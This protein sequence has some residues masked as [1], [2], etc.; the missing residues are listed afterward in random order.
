[1]SHSSSAPYVAE[2]GASA[3][4]LESPDAKRLRKAQASESPSIFADLDFAD[5]SAE[6]QTFSDDVLVDDGI[7]EE[8][9]MFKDLDDAPLP[10]FELHKDVPNEDEFEDSSEAI[11]D[12]SD[13]SCPEVFSYTVPTARMRS[14]LYVTITRP[15]MRML[16]ISILV[17][18]NTIVLGE[19]SKHTV[20]ERPFYPR[21][22][23]GLL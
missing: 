4:A 2:H 3:D 6:L 5:A 7:D 14:C 23:A 11:Y 16:M 17:R 19:Q 18:A 13:G 21:K 8:D 10:S 15:R 20:T 12:D 9:D 1:M 22:P